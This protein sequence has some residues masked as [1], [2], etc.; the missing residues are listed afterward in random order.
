[1]A[2]FEWKEEYS[3]HIAQIDAQHQNLVALLN[4]LFEAMQAG[5]GKEV[6]GKILANLVDY[7]VV[8]FQNEEKLLQSKGY[9]GLPAH[10]QEHVRFTQQVFDFQEQFASG[11]VALSVQISGFLKDWLSK[12][13]LQT[14]KQYSEY[15]TSRGVH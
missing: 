1:M 15:L 8:H 6:T 2:Y 11:K 5:K 9:P 3:V 13:I 14:D 4:E 12:H 7:T 10:C